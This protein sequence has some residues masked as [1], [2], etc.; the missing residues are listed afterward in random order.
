MKL[1]LNENP[2]FFHVN[3]ITIKDSGKIY[4]EPNEMI[5][6]V[7]KRGKE[8]DITAK[9]WGFYATPSINGRLKKEGFKTAL[10]KNEFNKIFIMVV[11]K[12]KIEIFK[13]YLNTHQNNKIICWL[14][15]FFMEEVIK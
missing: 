12:D 5:T 4:L 14:D 13:K 6:F 11:E 8:L 7:T 1:K 10:V 15:D 2:R 9:D 3:N